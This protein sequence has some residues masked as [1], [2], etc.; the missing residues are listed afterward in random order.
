MAS[1]KPEHYLVVD[2][3]QP[4]PEIA[5]LIRRRLEPLLGQAVRHSPDHA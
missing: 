3:T 1:A 2:A 4:A 5:D